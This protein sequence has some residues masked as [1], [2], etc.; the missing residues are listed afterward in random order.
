MGVEIMLASRVEMVRSVQPPRF[1]WVPYA[2]ALIFP[3]DNSRLAARSPDRKANPRRRGL[4]AR[5]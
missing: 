2:Y 1:R 3:P 4:V 5:V